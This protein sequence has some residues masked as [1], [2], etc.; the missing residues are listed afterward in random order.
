MES[1]QNPTDTNIANTAATALVMPAN[2]TINATNS[3]TSVFSGTTGG[4]HGI[5]ASGAL[6]I[7]GGSTLNV[8]REAVRNVPKL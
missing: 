7:N 2:S 4:T 6:T 5:N 3:I 1:G 8:T